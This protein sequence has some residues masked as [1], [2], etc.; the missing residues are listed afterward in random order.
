VIRHKY[1]HEKELD[2][3]LE[4]LVAEAEASAKKGR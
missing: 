1:L 4:K 2:K 3:P